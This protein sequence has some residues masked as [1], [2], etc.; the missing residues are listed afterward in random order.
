MTEYTPAQKKSLEL[1]K[2]ISV[3]AG[4][5][6]GKTFLLTQRYIS[7]L[8]SGAYPKDIVALT[9]TEKAAS[10]MQTKISRE[11]KKQAKTKPRMQ[12]CLDSF[13]QGTIS[14]FHGF[15]LSI[16]KEF[17]YEANLEPGFTIMDDLDKAE[18]VENTIRDVIENPGDD[19]FDALV[20]LHLR[21][22]QTSISD[23]VKLI[24]ENGDNRWFELLK[25]EPETVRRIWY[26]RFI[27]HFG[28]GDD[29]SELFDASEKEYLFALRRMFF[30]DS[31]NRVLL[32]RLETAD[33]KHLTLGRAKYLNLAKSLHKA[34]T[35]TEIR[36]L[37]AQCT[38]AVTAKKDFEIPESE[39]DRA[40]EFVNVFKA[41]PYLPGKDSEVFSVTREI[42]LDLY[43]AASV[44]AKK[45]AS[46]KKNAGI[47]DFDDI[48]KKTDELLSEKHPEI[49]DAV[50]SRCRYV[51]VD[52]VQDNDPALISLLRKI[53]G[54][55]SKNDRLFIVGDAKQSIYL[56]RGADSKVYA[57]FQGDFG[58]NRTALDT[59]FR[60]VPEI[61]NFVNK[62]FPE[63][64]TGKYDPVYDPIEPNRK[65]AKGS[66]SLITLLQ[67][68]KQAVQNEAETLASWIYDRIENQRLVICEDGGVCR[69]AEYSDVAILIRSRTHLDKL[70]AALDKYSV[71]YIEDGG[72][73]FYKRPEV[74]DLYNLLS[75]VLYAEDDLALYGALRS[76]YLSV[77]EAEL[78][79]AAFGSHK[80]LYVR[81]RS[82]AEENKESRI[83]FALAKISRWREYAKH[84]TP[85]LVLEKIISESEIL[86]VYAGLDGGDRMEANLMKLLGIARAKAVSSPFSLIEFVSLLEKSI[87]L[88]VADGS[89]EPLEE[90]SGRVRI[91]TIHSS[92]GL[93][94]PV[95]CL[96][97][98][99]EKTLGNADG[100]VFDDTLG[101]GVKIELSW[102]K[103]KCGLLHTA[104]EEDR[105][106]REMAEAKRLFYVALTRA[107]DHLVIS[108]TADEKGYHEKSF[109]SMY[110]LSSTG[111]DV[112]CEC[113]CLPA[114]KE[115]AESYFSNAVCAVPDFEDEEIVLDSASSFAMLRG[116]RLHAVFAGMS[117]DAE[118]EKQYA[119][120]MASSLMENVV[121]ERC[122]LPVICGGERRVID[123]FVQYADGTYAVID[124][125]TGSI[126]SA[127][128]RGFYD[129]YLE[130]VS[131][132]VRLMTD[133][134]GGTVFGWLYFADEEDGCRIVSV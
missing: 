14:T 96:C 106:N 3:T 74:M 129:G 50:S 72:K 42:L 79:K 94:Y 62:I 105:V 9:Y 33:K 115:A 109:M 110:N 134:T 23:Y 118:F 11:L 123:R 13:S 83:A 56:F 61:I 122:E 8:E 80:P 10:E 4:A 69:H 73:S 91:I 114:E 111:C 20:R 126:S 59:S 77:S 130:Q 25:G 99:G 1:G 22:H 37:F 40:N 47:L 100:V 48:I 95:V 65:S 52:E 60:S 127:K 17:A 46:A 101:A 54:D 121:F 49:L 108:A 68:K 58:E 107:R 113:C 45:I 131:D 35:H 34:E 57:E 43:D 124:Y 41:L 29:F 119:E 31:T 103:D 63:I 81:L 38:S 27:E 90:R 93:E 7:L 67:E 116:T 30:E 104:L 133:I 26:C 98:A 92:K 132:Y 16:L 66:V 28:I 18:L 125:K 82:F 120:F 6:T 71:P 102:M 39:L 15:C 86:A 84:M 36:S 75:A 87:E 97:F 78:E 89:A 85:S 70:C 44:C 53:C 12:E 128:E 19:L 2:S 55:V 112:C 76:P 24:I 64:F 32:N 5:G 117:D 21:M 88:N 51:L